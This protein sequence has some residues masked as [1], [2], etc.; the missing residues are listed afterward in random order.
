MIG[1][2][3]YGIRSVIASMNET[4]R[5]RVAFVIWSLGL[6]GAEQVVIRL[7]AALDRSRFEAVVCCLDEPGPFAPQAEEAGLEVVAMHKRGPVDPSAVWRLYRFF[8]DRAPD[9]VHTHLWGADLWGRLA[10]RAAGV[11]NLVSTAHNVDTWKRGY[12]FA[13]DRRLAPRTTHLVAVSG[14]V[15]EFYESHGVGR[16]RWRVI[17]NGILETKALPRVR[18]DAFR[19]LGIG[20]D[21]RVV[22]LVGRLVPAK[23]PQVFL[24]AVARASARVPNLKALVVGDG[25]LRDSLREEV[26]RL[27]LG[28]R[29]VFAGLRKDVPA[30]LAGTDQVVFSSEREGLS[31][32]MLEAMAAG[33]PVVA[34][35]VGGTPELIEDGASGILVPPGQPD[36]LGDRIAEVLLDAGL[37]GRLA[38]GARD[39]VGK[40]FSL[41]KMVADH[42][43]LYQDDRAAPRA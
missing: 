3:A 12:H 37:A 4:R 28:S 10:A 2:S 24:R 6:G 31:I 14:Q 33:V 21:D 34:T 26:A 39:R 35:R 42:Q 36:V 5:R 16:G 25:P 23:A 20:G 43:E 30:L 9:V 15:R 7:A 40:R 32:A 13:V 19:E 17:Y 29:V 41:H 18:G 22:G 38:A 8:R 1:A 11:R 27:G